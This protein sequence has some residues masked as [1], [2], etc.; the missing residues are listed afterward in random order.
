MKVYLSNESY[1]SV[2]IK[3]QMSTTELANI[4]AEKLNMDKSYGN[5]LD[6]YEIQK[7]TSMK[8]VTRIN[9]SVRKLNSGESIIEVRAK[10][11]TILGKSGNETLLHCRLVC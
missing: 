11:P 4:M 3:G 6:I 10:W 9:M 1:K 7:E 2:L 5:Y 8:V